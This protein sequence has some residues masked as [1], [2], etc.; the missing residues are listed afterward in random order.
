MYIPRSEYLI[1]VE[2]TERTF[3]ISAHSF[4]CFAVSREEAIGKMC[5]QRPEFRRRKILNVKELKYG[6]N[7]SN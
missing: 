3:N 4:E 5:T 7:K 6:Y 1:T 2:D